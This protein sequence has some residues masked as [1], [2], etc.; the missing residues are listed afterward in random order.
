MFQ[1]KFIRCVIL[2]ALLLVLLI[3]PKL[4]SGA[5]LEPVDNIAVQCTYF[6]EEITILNQPEMVKVSLSVY[7]LSAESPTQQ[8]KLTVASYSENF[9]ENNVEVYDVT[10]GKEILVEPIKS[11]YLGYFGVYLHEF[12]LIFDPPLLGARTINLFY[13]TTGSKWD[14]DQRNMILY[15][16]VWSPKIVPDENSIVRV[17]GEGD[18]FKFNTIYEP[19]ENWTLFNNYQGLIVRINPVALVSNAYNVYIHALYTPAYPSQWYMWEQYQKIAETLQQ[20]NQIIEQNEQGIRTTIFLGILG[21]VVAAVLSPYLAP[22]V[23]QKIKKNLRDNMKKR[24]SKKDHRENL[25]AM[26]EQAFMLML[27]II[28]GLFAMFGSMIVVYTTIGVGTALGSLLISI[29]LIFALFLAWRFE[30]SRER[31]IKTGIELGIPQTHKKH[32]I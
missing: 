6:W 7:N 3:S 19:W 29:L 21:I 30:K 2:S 22:R 18:G 27:S 20:I 23:M 11:D 28:A 5:M 10:F 16:Q 24:L 1:S 17:E 9:D 12:R 32:R 8:L 26:H 14:N 31:W 25:L 13:T 4:T 15:V